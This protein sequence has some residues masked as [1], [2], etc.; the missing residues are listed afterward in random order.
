MTV[1]DMQCPNCGAPVDFA[2]STQAT[3]SFCQSKLYF[4][5]EGVKVSSALSDRVESKAA[6]SGIDLAHVQQLVL[7]GK[8]IEA[9]KLVREQTGLGLKEAKDA[10]EAIERGETPELTLRATAITHGVSGI[11]LDQ[12][13]ELLLQN[14]KIEAIKL[15]REQTGLG[16]KEAKDAVEAIEATGWP[17]TPGDPAQIVKST[18]SRPPRTK[19][20]S[21]GCL[22]CLPILLF[23]GLCAGF[24]MLSGQV[25]FRV[26]G[27]LD[28]VLKILSNDPQVTQVLGQPISVGPFVT[29]KISGG[30]SSSSASFNVPIYGPKQSGDLSVSGSWRQGVWDL[31]IWVSYSSDDGEEQTIRIS[32]EVK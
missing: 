26:W 30:G 14:K 1:N 13:N 15:Y 22:S 29:G 16:L 11:D 20:S 21:A 4:T 23:I 32:Q 18:V 17:P 8:K 7:A 6:P 24:V 10:V 9:I 19:M 28:Q 12:I 3:C 27:P 2:G 31:T 5:A 25:G